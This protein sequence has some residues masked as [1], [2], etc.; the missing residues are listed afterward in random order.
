MC[1]RDRWKFTGDVA[2]QS[3]YFADETKYRPLFN[4]NKGK[5]KEINESNFK[6]YFK[7]ILDILEINYL[8]HYQIKFMYLILSILYG[9]NQIIGFN[10]GI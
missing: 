4:K 10:D 6:Y 5:F 7:T 9:T 2:E 1:I 8:S 3:I